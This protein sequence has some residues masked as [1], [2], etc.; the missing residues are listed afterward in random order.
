M[1][2]EELKE[3]YWNKQ[4]GETPKQHCWFCQFL[5]YTDFNIGEF[6]KYIT[7]EEFNPVDKAGYGK[8][9]TLKTMYNWS[10]SNKWKLRKAR[11]LE[12]REEQVQ[13]Q[14]MQLDLEKRRE[15]YD[16]KIGLIE[17]AFVK[18]N[19]EFLLG[20]ISGYQFN[21]YCQGITKLLDDNRLDLNKSTDIVTSNASVEV[22][23]VVESDNGKA[24]EIL[25]LLEEARHGSE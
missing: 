5:Q 17:A 16:N 22:D 3:P 10:Y 21:Q 12:D 18:A 20:N 9:P 13:N 23:A 24:D 1:P 11:Y 8:A 2:V 4:E 15:F 6:H 7:S 19:E 25:R 14:L